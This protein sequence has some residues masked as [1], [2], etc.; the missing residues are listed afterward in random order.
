MPT[1]RE[2]VAVIRRAVLGEVRDDRG[3]RDP[4]PT[5]RHRGHF[6]EGAD[7][8][9]G[10]RREPVDEAAALEE[11]GSVAA[12]E[13]HGILQ[14]PVKRGDV[15]SG[16]P[17][18]EFAGTLHARPQHGVEVQRP[19]DVVVVRAL[20]A[21]REPAVAAHERVVPGEVGGDVLRRPRATDRAQEG[22]DDDAEPH[23]VGLRVGLVAD[24]GREIGDDALLRERVEA[25]PDPR[26]GH[27]EDERDRGRLDLGL[28]VLVH[29]HP[30][31]GVLGVDTGGDAA[32][33]VGDELVHSFAARARDAEAR[34]Q[35]RAREAFEPIDGSAVAALVARR[36]DA[37]EV[38][39]C[40]GA[41]TGE[42]PIG[43]GEPLLAR[44][45]A[46]ERCARRRCGGLVAHGFSLEV[47]SVGNNPEH[48][49]RLAIQ[50]DH[51]KSLFES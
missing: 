2:Q 23:P 18:R 10:G 16:A 6:G 14:E 34:E 41:G 36:R 11:G 3:C 13:G 43:V 35:E 17:A 33:V 24:D 5:E 15:A 47:L 29:P 19:A 51:H 30:A 38:V 39:G 20:V 8:E 7:P 21:I 32:R 25:V 46:H 37:G 1:H 50:T 48:F 22:L 44:P 42:K 4:Q 31:V 9:G 26:A 45:V 27:V 40:P 12:D 28:R 49:G